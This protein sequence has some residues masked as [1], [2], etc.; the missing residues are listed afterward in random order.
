MGLRWRNLRKSTSQA[1]RFFQSQRFV[2]H[3]RHLVH[4]G[5][6]WTTWLLSQTWSAKRR[7]IEHHSGVFAPHSGH[8]WCVAWRREV[9]LGGT[10][11]TVSSR[12]SW[13]SWASWASRE[14]HA[15]HVSRRWKA[16][17]VTTKWCVAS[18]ETRSSRPH[19]LLRIRSS[20]ARWLAHRASEAR[21]RSNV[22]SFLGRQRHSWL[23]A[24]S[25]E[26]HIRHM[27][28]GNAHVC[29]LTRNLACRVATLQTYGRVFMAREAHGHTLV[30]I[31][32][33]VLL[34]LLLLH[35]DLLTEFL[36]SSLCFATHHLVLVEHARVF[37]ET[38]WG[39]T[40]AF[41]WRLVLLIGLLIE[42]GH[43]RVVG[44]LAGKV[45]IEHL[46]RCGAGR[47]L[48]E[49]EQE[50]ALT[51]LRRLVSLR[52]FASAAIQESSKVRVLRVAVP[53]GW[54]LNWKVVL[55]PVG[56][57]SE[58]L[59]NCVF[60]RHGVKSCLLRWSRLRCG[61]WG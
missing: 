3:G 10:L 29:H 13:A 61:A 26:W 40:T 1:A 4:V 49:G 30:L 34:L 41:R 33:V 15:A 32:H 37:H 57:R 39:A 16:G 59:V 24:A 52:F 23:T 50:V 35:V 11:H 18:R 21:R 17:W 5:R 55:R 42:E 45:L 46:G 2:C 14:A 58:L 12:S 38:W 6:A 19:L 54:L 28:R 43:V 60:R 22:L 20:K 36:F 27:L 53:R 9:S 44:V 56:R 48:H 7:S 25:H 47:L 31:A 8:G 51:L